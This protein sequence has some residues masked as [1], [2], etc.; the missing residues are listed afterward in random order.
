MLALSGVGST[1]AGVSKLLIGGPHIEAAT[2]GSS[3]SGE[4]SEF[5]LHGVIG[6][7]GGSGIRRFL[8]AR[9]ARGRDQPQHQYSVHDLLI[10]D[11]GLHA[12]SAI[13]VRTSKRRHPI[14]D[15]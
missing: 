15:R 7:G 5:Q 2:I 3:R 10:V 8:T 4:F 6:L 14:S 1:G 13:V 12:W 9:Q 11:Q